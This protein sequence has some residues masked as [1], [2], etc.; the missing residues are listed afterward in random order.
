ML[1]CYVNRILSNVAAVPA[2]G[3]K[4]FLVLFDNQTWQ[5]NALKFH[6][7]NAWR[8]TK[9]VPARQLI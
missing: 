3:S 9:D 4:S 6:V 1:I 2:S 8:Q 5:W 7:K